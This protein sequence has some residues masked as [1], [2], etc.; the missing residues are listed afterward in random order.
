MS[1]ETTSSKLDSI[2]GSLRRR[3]DGTNELR[4]NGSSYDADGAGAQIAFTFVNACGFQ[5]LLA[6]TT[7]GVTWLGI[8]ALPAYLE[9]ELRRDFTRA[10]IRRDD[11][12]AGD[13]AAYVIAEL[14]GEAPAFEL[15]LD[16]RATPFQLQVWRELCAV[17]RG[18]T[19]SY[20]EIASRID[21]PDAARAV[22][23]ANGSNPTSIIIPCHRAI[24]ADGSLTG[25]RWGIEIKRQLLE[26][27]RAPL[28]RSV[29]FA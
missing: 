25:Y 10:E 9:S 15:P 22:G 16:I 19:R 3:G 11:S 24:G 14:A 2:F 17:P 12:W 4:V 18:A 26:L 1:L 7:Q 27:E 20:G 29:A 28:A 6:A 23:Q 8:H 5:M 13:L 21:H